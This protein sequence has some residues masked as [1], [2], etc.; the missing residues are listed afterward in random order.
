[1]NLTKIKKDNQDR[2]SEAWLKLCNYIDECAENGTEEFFPAKYL[3][4]QF[5]QIR[6]LP[7]SIAKLKHVKKMHLYGSNLVSIPPQ[8]GEMHA[9]EVFTP[10]TSEN[11]CWF[12]YEITRC[13][14][15]KDSTVS[16]R[17]IYGN[18][19]N[20]KTF[21]DLTDNPVTYNE[22]IIRCS[23]CNKEMIHSETHQFWISLWVGTDVLPLLVN[24]C[25][26][27]CGSMLPKGAEGYIPYAHK[28]GDKPREISAF[29]FL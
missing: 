12:P 16:T 25:S 21:P 29:D 22:S 5:S 24:L 4:E 2:N 7:E 14:K 8:I 26:L 11:L 15:L 28:G 19:K 9:L 10:Y 3:K 13:K 20:K 27:D 17:V 1:M 6:T 18:K 23:I